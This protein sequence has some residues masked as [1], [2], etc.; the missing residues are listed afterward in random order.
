MRLRCAGASVAPGRARA[1]TLARSRSS[2]RLV[3]G[4]REQGGR[5]GRVAE[6]QRAAGGVA[7]QGH[8]AGVGRR[9]GVH[10]VRRDLAGRRSALAQDPR[11]VPVQ[12]LALGGRQVAVDRRAQ[13]RVG[14][15]DRA[16]GFHDAG[17]DQRR[18]RLLELGAL[19]VR[20]VAPASP[21]CAPSPSTLS[22]RA[23]GG[24]RRGEPRQTEQDRVGD[25]ARDDRAD[26]GG[27]GRGG[28]EAAGRRLA[29]QL[30]DEER[31]AARHLQAA[32][33]RT[34]RR[35]R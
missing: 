28:I 5:A 24:R 30:A 21:T 8:R 4:T 3:E 22:A 26:I 12:P 16:A 1:G 6:R 29:E 34:D 19:R 13:D 18:H 10:D 35:A 27:G 2:G 14:E 33:G 25:A 20:R 11:R 31:I 15:A 32:R 7:Q 9:L 23:S 17:G